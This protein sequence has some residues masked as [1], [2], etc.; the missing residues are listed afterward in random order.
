MSNWALIAHGGARTWNPEEHAACRAGMEA[1]VAV[2]VRVLAN[3]GN[4]LDAVERVVCDLENDPTFNAGCGA[5]RNEVGGLQLD[6][7]IMDGNTLDIGAVIGLKEAANPVSVARALLRQ[8][9]ILLTGEGAEAFARATG[10]MRTTRGVP[11]VHGD[12]CDTVGCVALDAN[13]DLA[14]ATSTGGLDGARVG[15]AGD[16]SL[17]GCGFYADNQ[18]GAVGLSGEGE[19]IARVLMAGEFLHMLNHLPPA[20]A[21]RAVLRRL[22]VVGGE[23]GLIAIV[24][25]GRLCWDH[26]SPHFAVAWADAGEPAVT[27]QLRKGATA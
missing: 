14:V 15:R 3:G 26:N 16:V 22:D 6:A 25:D 23:A 21:A 20:E 12:V 9:E 24:P 4:A 10:R 8:K 5:A 17:P 1:A 2:G 11:R 13:G 27:V 18:R 19:E 7:S